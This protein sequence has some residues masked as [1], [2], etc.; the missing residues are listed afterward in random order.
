MGEE[1]A[2]L[3]PVH[4]VQLDQMQMRQFAGIYDF[5][6][7]KRNA[8]SAAEPEYSLEEALD[9]LVNIEV[10]RIAVGLFYDWFERYRIDPKTTVA[11]TFENGS[12]YLFM[13][14][15][16]VWYKYEIVPVSRQADT[17]MCITKH[18]DER[19]EFH[20]KGGGT[21]HLIHMDSSGKQIHAHKLSHHF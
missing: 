19:L 20:I 7:G 8:D 12:L 21:V 16:K 6:N 10:P 15:H 11:V 13:Q 2:V 4:P 3:G 17:I 14:K 9:Q 18:I 5:G 1:V